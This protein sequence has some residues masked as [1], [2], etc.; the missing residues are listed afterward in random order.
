MKYY[1]VRKGRQTGIFTT[2]DA[3]EKQVKGYPGAKYKSFKV[4]SEAEQFLN[5]QLSS[6]SHQS[7]KPDVKFPT[8]DADDIILY[9]DGGSR[10]HGNVKGGHVK[11]NDKAAW[12][13]L[14]VTP[15]NRF[16]DSGG[17]FGATN[18]RMEIMALY[19][20]LAYLNAHDLQDS[21]IHAVLD[22]KYVL[23]AIN[24]NWLKGWQ[25]RGWT[26]SGGQKLENKE[27]WRSLAQELRNFPHLSLYWTKGHADNEGNVF[28]DRLLNETMDKMKAKTPQTA[29]QRRPV[30]QPAAKPAPSKTHETDL[31]PSPDTEKS[32]QDI[33]YNLK[34]LGLFDDDDQ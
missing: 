29:S 5:G 21:H 19:E 12:A 33:E 30:S 16:S 8:A 6:T 25:R 9:T 10:N 2:W 17:E 28:V 18:N 27:L 7:G 20:A 32:V 34:Q 11:T 22:S 13:Y 14:I 3:A 4:K 24:K 31:K 23:N 1:A 26:R 15:T